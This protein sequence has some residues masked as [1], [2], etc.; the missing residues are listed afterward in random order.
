ME[1]HV[2]LKA[3]GI[4][5]RRNKSLF[6]LVFLGEN[7]RQI[8]D[9]QEV[10]IRCASGL[11]ISRGMSLRELRKQLVTNEKRALVV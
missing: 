5:S 7:Q 2:P 8:A 9:R 6:F 4:F 11:Q 10:Q 3:L 1:G